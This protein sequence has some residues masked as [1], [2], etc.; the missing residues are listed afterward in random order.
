MIKNRSQDV[1]QISKKDKQVHLNLIY[2]H[3]VSSN[4]RQADEYSK[5]VSLSIEAYLV[6]FDDEDQDVYFVAEECLN[7]TIKAL[8]DT[9]LIRVQY[10]LYRFLR[11]DGAERG[12]KGALVRFAELSHLV[13]SHK[14]R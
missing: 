4:L 9:N 8:I 3:V 7:K 6:Y 2:D 14:C 1:K 12:L 10:E 13:K 11:R 5:M